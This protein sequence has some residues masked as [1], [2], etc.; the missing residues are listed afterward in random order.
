MSDFVAPA[1]ATKFAWGRQLWHDVLDLVFPP[2]CVHCGRLDTHWCDACH[3][4]L[5]NEPL[6]PQARQLD[7]LDACLATAS[8]QGILQDAI[9][10]LKYHG[11][12][13]LALDLGQRLAQVM[14]ETA[15]QASFILPI[16]LHTLRYAKRGYNQS[17]L[18]AQTMAQTLNIPCQ[19]QV[20]VRHR[21][22]RPQVGL[23]REGRLVNVQAAFISTQSL[24]GQ[25]LVL[26][27]DVRTTG[28]T[29][30]ACAQAARDAGAER[31]Y[32]L[33]VT[34]AL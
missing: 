6:D 23:Q 8:H 30:S 28:A 18:L 12:T 21:N 5:L 31:V 27:D 4:L 15:W 11:Q 16:P 34:S 26:V 13:Q 24:T 29:L 25:S 7:H 2:R 9:Q 20:I 32:A 22:T 19:S 17:E 10:A 1:P 14:R 33:T 3:Q